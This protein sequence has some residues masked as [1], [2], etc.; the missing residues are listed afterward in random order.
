MKKKIFSRFITLIA[1]FFC[2]LSLNAEFFV[3]N[4]NNIS[5]ATLTS[6]IIKIER[7]NNLIKEPIKEKLPF[8]KLEGVELPGGLKPVLR[9]EEPSDPLPEAYCMRDDYILYDSASSPTSE[10]Q[11]A[12]L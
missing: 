7:P 1:I 12:Y 11:L 9:P 3:K 4:N 6:N 5:T 10:A 8:D 2:A